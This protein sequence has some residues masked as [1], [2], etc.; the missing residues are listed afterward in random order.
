ME[1]GNV[2]IAARTLISQCPRARTVQS[3]DRATYGQIALDMASQGGPRHADYDE[4]DVETVTYE[5]P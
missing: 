1:R 2:R 3:S 4:I 5:R